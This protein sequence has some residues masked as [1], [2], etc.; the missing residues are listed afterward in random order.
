[1]LSLRGFAKRRGLAYGTVNRYYT[2]GRLPPHDGELGDGDIDEGDDDSRSKP[3]VGWL[4][5]TVDHWERPG[6]GARTD[7]RKGSGG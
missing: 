6:Q 2:E 4:A 1:M 5:E 7:L 3:R